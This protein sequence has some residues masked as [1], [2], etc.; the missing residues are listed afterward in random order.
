MSVGWLLSKNT[1]PVGKDAAR[2]VKLNDRQV[3]WV[4][5]TPDNPADSNRVFV[6]GTPDEVRGGALQACGRTSSRDSSAGG[7]G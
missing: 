4:G 2:G 7:A 6:Y 5:G 1:L 3:L